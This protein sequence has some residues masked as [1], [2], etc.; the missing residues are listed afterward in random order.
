[1][2]AQPRPAPHPGDVTSMT[3][4]VMSS[5]NAIAGTLRE[6][7][8]TAVATRRSGGHVPAALTIVDEPPDRAVDAL[9]ALGDAPALAVAATPA[10]SARLLDAGARDTIADP[11]DRATLV[12]RVRASLELVALRRL[13]TDTGALLEEKVRMR[14]RELEDARREV[15]D[16]LVRAA[17]YRDDDTAEHTRRVGET[18]ALLAAAAGLDAGECET[19]RLAAP[20]H[21]I[22]KI[23]V[24]DSTLLKPGPLEADE[25]ERIRAHTVIGGRIL[26]GSHAVVLKAAQ[27]IALF[28]HE[29]WDGA[30]YPAGFAGEDIPL[31]ARIVAIADVFD[32]LTHERP[33]KKRWTVE[34]SLAEIERLAGNHLDPTL[35]AAFVTLIRQGAL[36]TIE[37]S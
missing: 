15:L 5:S 7:G 20:L 9:R 25:F 22:G 33:Y 35:A 2:S 10:D 21:D 13:L 31:S 12:A 34:Q 23:G 6:A 27:E 18:S 19:I 3:I 32:A 17:E 36:E 37:W 1:M 30:G 28:H 11:S 16:R 29:R 24:P 4:V 14:T 26:W 8:F